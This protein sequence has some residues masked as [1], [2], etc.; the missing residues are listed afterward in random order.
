MGV[1]GETDDPE[2]LAARSRR[3]RNMLATL[4]LSQGTPMILAGDEM[5]NSQGGNNN[6]YCQDNEIGWVDWTGVDQGFRDFV[7]QMIAFRMANPILRQKRF[8]HSQERDDGKQDLFWWR[9]D[10]APMTDEDWADP[11]LKLV[12]VEKRTAADS[13]DYAALDDAIFA[14]FNAGDEA[15]VVVPPATEG[16]LWVCHVDTARPDSPPSAVPERFE[17]AAHSVTVLVKDADE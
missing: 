3:K 14:I 5:G 16:R 11:D 2:I 13:P 6:A 1:E 7:A 4:L 12:V 8:L 10:G 9:A 17:V 15:E